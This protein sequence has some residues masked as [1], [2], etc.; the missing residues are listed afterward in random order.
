MSNILLIS[1]IILLFVAF[2][3]QLS[4]F[5]KTFNK[6]KGMKM[7]FPS[8]DELRIEIVEEEQESV[9]KIL[10]KHDSELSSGF[11]KILETINK[12][13]QKSKGSVEGSMSTFSNLIT[14]E[15]AKLEDEIES[16]LSAP[17]Y[18]GLGGTLLGI[19]F[20]VFHLV[21]ATKDSD[22]AELNNE[23]ING[24]FLAVGLAVIV[25][26]IGL[27]F[28]IINSNFR[29]KHAKLE[30]DSR[31]SDVISFL[32]IELLPLVS[33]STASAIYSLREN[34]SHFNKEFGRNLDVYKTNFGLI[35]ENLK[36]QE[37]VLTLLSKN[38]L[39]ETAKEIANMLSDIDS[40]A[41]NFKV[42]KDY[43]VQLLN[44][45]EQTKEVSTQFNATLDSFSNFN[46]KLD[47]MADFVESQTSFNKQF[48]GF[49]SN[50]F[51]ENESA[52]EIYNTQWREI[53]NKLIHDIGN[54]SKHITSYFETVNSEVN[55]FAGNNSS[56][57]ESFSGFKQAIEVL[58]KNS[59]M[60]YKAFDTISKNMQNMGNAIKE[61]GSSISELVKTVK[62][63]NLN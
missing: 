42:F 32:E 10:K 13:L 18:V 4:T 20:G 40:V 45:F 25:S 31:Q 14:R 9:I 3:I 41:K 7:F 38:N 54:N 47:N 11:S 21:S 39:A 26:L 8:S 24:L 27:I 36:N 22:I 33:E 57:F 53:G 55:K 35:N 60:S 52:R 17:L 43:Q 23:A 28:V 56:F 61:Q 51:P 15:K 59:E 12:F 46:M 37:R 30:C 6:I 50:N 16:Q 62:S 5:K 1:E 49:L 48:Q 19:V 44:S 34:L 2:L 58:I 63:N 29:Y